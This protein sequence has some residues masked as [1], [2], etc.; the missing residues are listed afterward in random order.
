MNKIALVSANTYQTPYPV[1]PLGVSYL[2][3]YLQSHI[4][5]IDIKLF[6]FN[7]G[8]DD[9]FARFLSD[10]TFDF[11]GV[12]LRNIDD[13]N[14]FAQNNFIV[15]YKKIM[16]I[17]RENSRAVIIIGGPAFSIFPQQVFNELQPDYAIKGEGEESLRQL[18][19]NL[20]ENKDVHN[21][22][23]L[24]YRDAAG[25]VQV[26]RHNCYISSPVLQVDSL[27][28]EE[29]WN[30]SGML[31]IQT[32]R[33][34][35]YNCIYCSY[36][37]IDGKRVRTLDVQTVV[38][39]IEEMYYKKGINYL[40][41]TDSIFNIHN[42]Y[43][44]ELAHRLIESKMNISWGAYFSPN[45]LTLA[46]LKL[47]KQA[48]LTHV[49]FGTD[50]FSDQQ[51]KN[52]NKH[53]HFS[54]ILAH[55]RNCEDL[56]IFYAHFLIL[57]GYG[58]TE[59]T[60]NETFE[61]SKQLGITVIF[62]FVGMRIYPE[63]ALCDIALKEGVISHRNELINPVYYVSKDIN[64]DTMEAR[65]MATGKKWFFPNNNTAPMSDRF[66]AKKIKGPLWEYMRY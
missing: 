61:H 58:E 35:P 39:N 34:C 16:S 26:N 8:G 22:E 5:D 45:N 51:L 32:K 41:F 46:M 43:N 49:E 18:I 31:N 54:D 63:T 64:I 30:K 56:G 47:F 42:D 44:E 19:T 37:G 38:A 59:D 6:D 29:Y 65:A 24:V 14:I 7:M 52:M 40:F 23:G 12:S 13:V 3:T 27:W 4:S 21:I 17:A 2:A 62:P 57:G 11:I 55:S 9:E 28:A 50:S 10:N 66:R 20:S 25:V 60:L 15:G 33:G 36:P 48:G 53:F 1:Y